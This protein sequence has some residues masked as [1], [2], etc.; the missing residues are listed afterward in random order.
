MR[1]LLL[2]DFSE[3][4]PSDKNENSWRG[5]YDLLLGFEKEPN[6]NHSQ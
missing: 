3:V 6:M 2:V 1:G 4:V 5:F